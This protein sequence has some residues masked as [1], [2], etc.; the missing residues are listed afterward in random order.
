MK[1]GMQT[2]VTNYAMQ[3]TLTPPRTHRFPLYLLQ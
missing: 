2:P 1:T 3:Y